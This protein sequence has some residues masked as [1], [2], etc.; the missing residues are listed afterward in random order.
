MRSSGRFRNGTERETGKKG[1]TDLTKV[2]EDQQRFLVLVEKTTPTPIEKQN[3]RRMHDCF[4]F[5]KF[6]KDEA[7]KFWRFYHRLRR[8]GPK[9][10]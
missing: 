2:P 7:R 6:T 3:L 1:V 4:T 5:L 9:I 8:K 10:P